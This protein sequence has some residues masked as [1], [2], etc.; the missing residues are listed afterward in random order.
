MI[1][2]MCVSFQ[3]MAG[4]CAALTEITCMY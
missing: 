4:L 3:L 1:S 2:F